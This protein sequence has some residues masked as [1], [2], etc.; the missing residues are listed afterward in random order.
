M[1]NLITICALFGLCT[2][3][4]VISGCGPGSKLTEIVAPTRARLSFKLH[5]SARPK[6]IVVPKTRAIPE[7]AFSVEFT[8]TPVNGVAVTRTTQRP[9]SEGPVD[10]TTTFDNVPGGSATV[11]AIIRDAS[12]TEIGRTNQI[13]L[14]VV[15]GQNTEVQLT[16]ISTTDTNTGSVT[17]TIVEN[18]VPPIDVP[19]V[20]VPPVDVP[21]VDVPPV[22]VPPVDVPPV[23]VPPVDVP[24]VDVPPVDIPVTHQTRI[25]ISFSPSQPRYPRGTPIELRAKL[26]SPEDLRAKRQKAHFIE[27]WTV[28]GTTRKKSRDLGDSSTDDSGIARFKYTVTEDPLKDDVKIRVSY[29]GKDTSDG[30]NGWM[31]HSNFGDLPIG[32]L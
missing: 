22:D 8:L 29:D 2:V 24:P 26:Y 3:L 1:K 21:P 7:N 31:A 13:P 17:V 5:W 25:A 27:E 23:D 11:M 32:R 10:T 4:P 6:T 19:P 14:N 12:N 16:L 9:D 28:Q 15:A 20:D 18:D 30:T